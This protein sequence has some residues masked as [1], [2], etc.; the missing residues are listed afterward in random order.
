MIITFHARKRF[1]QRFKEL[2]PDSVDRYM[3]ADLNKSYHAY[4][5]NGLQRWFSP[6]RIMYLIDVRDG[7]RIVITCF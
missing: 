7:K 4:A 1:C 3:E 6:S 5:V 2:P